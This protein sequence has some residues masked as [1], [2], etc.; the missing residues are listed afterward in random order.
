M[1]DG[2]V[3]GADVVVVGAVAGAVADGAVDVAGVDAA[4]GGTVDGAVAEGVVDVVSAVVVLLL[5]QASMLTS[6]RLARMISGRRRLQF[7]SVRVIRAN[8]NPSTPAGQGWNGGIHTPAPRRGSR[9][10]PAT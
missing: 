4:V 6:A 9:F 10:D 8:A 1:P 3:A 5:L 2:S 7:R